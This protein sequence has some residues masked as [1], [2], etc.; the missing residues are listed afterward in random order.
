VLYGVKSEFVANRWSS[1]TH[2]YARKAIDSGVTEETIAGKLLSQNC[3][4]LV[5]AGY[6]EHIGNRDSKSPLLS[7]ALQ[8]LQEIAP[9]ILQLNRILGQ[10]II[11]GRVVC[12]CVKH[13]D[14]LLFNPSAMELAFQDEAEDNSMGH[15]VCM[16]AFGLRHIDSGGKQ[17][18]LLKQK[19][20]LGTSLNG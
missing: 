9:L 1:L 15:V 6:G 14:T 5:I 7:M 4:F 10:E 20:V 13:A 19:V 18:V 17:V 8:R 16:T 2:K 3:D 11:H 12:T